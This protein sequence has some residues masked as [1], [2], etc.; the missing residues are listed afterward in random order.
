MTI[1]QIRNI[2][3]TWIEKGLPYGA[4]V[5][6]A[7]I[8]SL[9]LN[10]LRGDLPFPLMVLRESALAHNLSE[11][12]GWCARNRFE[13]APHGKTTMCPQIYARQI[14]AGA[15][16]ITVGNTSQALVCFQLGIGRILLANQVVGPANV[17]SLV[18]AMRA[19]PATGLYSIAD[20]VEGV[21]H[22]A[23][24]MEQAGAERP[25]GMLVEFGRSG[26][27]TGVHSP[28]AARPVHEAILGHTRY[29]QFRGVEAFEGHAKTDEEALAFLEELVCVGEQF[30]AAA[31]EQRLLFSAGG[32]TFLKPLSEVLRC[33]DRSRWQPVIRSGCYVT[34]DHGIYAKKQDSETEA[35]RTS[36]PQFRAA[37][38]L[39]G[40]VQS[41]PEPDVAI[42]TFGKRDCAYD[43]ALPV[44]LDLPA[45]T[46]FELNDQH[47]FLR[48][49]GKA[50]LAIGDK[51]RCGICHPCTAF[52]K[53][54]VIPVVDDDYNVIDLYR[55]YF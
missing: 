32:S 21:H 42:L 52:D 44:P 30:A 25:I 45:A 7:H 43:I 24:A 46:I 35:D 1:S 8:R 26:W 27:R 6:P 2:P 13:I 10:V 38:E 51:V 11:M 14:E 9:G 55:T 47:A 28:E 15:W 3:V 41:M 20:S 36:L 33:L 19:Y 49:D 16:G 37:L 34:H 53:W 54:R 5:A 17:R 31:G 18:E 22:L 23:R 12:A 50:R 4:D 48:H 29:L 40:Y 39:W